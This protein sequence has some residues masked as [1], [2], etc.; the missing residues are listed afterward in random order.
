MRLLWDFFCN[1][2]AVILMGG[3]VTAVAF[4]L[5]IEH[6]DTDLPDFGQ[7]ASYDPAVVTR[8]YADD[9]RLLAEY[10]EQR[11][12]YVP[13]TAIPKRVIQAFIAAEDRNFYRHQG[14]DIYGIG[15]AIVTNVSNMGQNHSLVGGSTITQQVVKNF[16]LTNEKSFQRKIKEAILAYRI[17]KIYSKDRILELYLNEIYLGRGAYGV[18]SAA[19][20]YFNKPLENLTIEEAAFLA[21]LPKAPASYDPHLHYDKRQRRAATG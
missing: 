18:A 10:A 11:R 19:L 21:S 17:S 6:Y 9:D 14:I 7:L 1:I 12:V 15:R 20:T 3:V 4:I 2:L 5:I 13:L 16:L 8:L